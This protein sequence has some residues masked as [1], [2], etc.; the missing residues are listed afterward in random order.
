MTVNSQIFISCP[1]RGSIR[2]RGT[3]RPG[4]R[5]WGVQGAQVEGLAA[6]AGLGAAAAA[7]GVDVAAAAALAGLASPAPDLALWA[8]DA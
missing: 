2:P 4:W 3:A 1:E 7:V 8:R 5:R 6:V